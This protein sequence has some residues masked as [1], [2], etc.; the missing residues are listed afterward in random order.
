MATTKNTNV[1]TKEN[2]KNKSLCF[3]CGK[4]KTNG[5]TK[6]GSSFYKST[7]K[8]YKY[9]D[10]RMVHC[11]ECVQEEYF[12]NIQKTNNIQASIKAT[13]MTFNIPFDDVTLETV[14]KKYIIDDENEAMSYET[15]PFKEYMRLLNSLASNG[16]LG[17]SN[18][19][20]DFDSLEVYKAIENVEIEE[21][22]LSPQEKVNKIQREAVMDED[23]LVA[24]KDCIMLL[25]ADPFVGSSIFDQKYLYPTLLK[26]LDEATLEDPFKLSQVL[27]IVNNNNQVRKIDLLINAISSDMNSMMKNQSE[28]KSLTSTKKQIVE[29]TDKIAKENAISVKNRGDKK[30]GQ[31]TL[32][33]LMKRLR[34]LDFED[35]EADYYDVLKAKGMQI[36]SDISMKSIFEQLQFDE[37]DYTEMIKEQRIMIDSLNK[38]LDEVLEENRQ[39][40]SEKE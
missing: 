31:S 25:E 26:F 5:T 34:E 24:K 21:S 1:K 13:C 12:N 8:L 7:S 30:A 17:Q 32:T 28:I 15:S 29:N 9:N 16:N 39:L 10:Y 19:I 27:Q 18:Y 35:A 38:K 2:Y 6:G 37:N 4:W 14:K 11:K 36:A 40:H 23:E 33:Y 22:K 20:D 3:C